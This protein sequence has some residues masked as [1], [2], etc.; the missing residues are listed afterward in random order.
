MKG[1]FLHS[2]ARPYIRITWEDFKDYWCPTPNPWLPESDSLSWRSRNQYFPNISL[3]DSE[4]QTG[5]QWDIVSKE[6]CESIW[7]P[8]FLLQFCGLRASF[9]AQ[10]VKN[11][12]TVQET[13]VW[14]LSREDPLEKEMATHSSVLAWKI[15]WTEEPGG[16]QSMGSPRGRHDWTT[17][18]SL[19]EW[20]PGE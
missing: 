15:P 13:R 19:Q 9:I 5:K 14:S 4:V 6:R 17:N 11:L 3:C 8:R 18:T 12:P 2:E 10:L 20:M 1:M 7:S 16:L